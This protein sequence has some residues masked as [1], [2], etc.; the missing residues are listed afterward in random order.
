MVPCGCGSCGCSL[1]SLEVH[2]PGQFLL[3]VQ[4]TPLRHSD[5]SSSSFSIFLY[6]GIPSVLSYVLFC[7]PSCLP[8]YS[9]LLFFLLPVLFS[10]SLFIHFIFWSPLLFSFQICYPFF[11]FFFSYYS[12][13]SA[14][15][16]SSITIQS[17]LFLLEPSTLS[18]ASLLSFLLLLLFSSSFFYLVRI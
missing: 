5:F 7:S 6:F 1:V 9:F 14:S 2:S 18:N 17:V 8:F 12:I 11:S 16:S 4:T 15:P 3:I 10:P 13:L